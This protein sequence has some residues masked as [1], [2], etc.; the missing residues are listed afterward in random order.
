MLLRC[1]GK[2]LQ[3]RFARLK[4]LFDVLAA[5]SARKY[6]DFGSCHVDGQG[7]IKT[8]KGTNRRF[9][10]HPVDAATGRACLFGYQ[11]PAKHC[12]RRRL[13]VRRR[14]NQL[15]AARKAAPARQN[16]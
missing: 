3:T 15:D 6:H 7:Q 12:G 10:Q 13:D 1:R 16:L 14:R 11:G 2:P 8:A 9:H 4:P 5:F